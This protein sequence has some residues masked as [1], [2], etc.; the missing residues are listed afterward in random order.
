MWEEAIE[1]LVYV[2]ERERERV[3][4]YVVRGTD[5]TSTHVSHGKR[6]NTKKSRQVH[7]IYM[8]KYA[9][10]YTNTYTQHLQI[11]IFT[12]QSTRA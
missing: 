11:H 4:V 10:M 7:E 1:I 8:S 6:I 9:F 2:W 5:N 3:S 12:E